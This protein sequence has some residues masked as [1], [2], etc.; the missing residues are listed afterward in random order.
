MT[1]TPMTTT[2]WTE[3]KV[4]YPISD[5]DHTLRYLG[6]PPLPSNWSFER[7]ESTGGQWVIIFSIMG[8]P[9]LENGEIVKQILAEID[10]LK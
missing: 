4:A 10:S 6:S 7:F 2:P 5:P 9:T 3:C 8:L 1:T